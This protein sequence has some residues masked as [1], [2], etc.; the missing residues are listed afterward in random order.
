MHQLILKILTLVMVVSEKTK[1]D[2]FFN[3]YG[4]CNN[5]TVSVYENGFNA[6]I[7]PKV[8][9]IYFETLSTK[10]ALSKLN[11]IKDYLESLLED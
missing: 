7:K 4:H 5:I 1:H 8:F 9:D 10:K 11:E 3:F 2:A 6:T